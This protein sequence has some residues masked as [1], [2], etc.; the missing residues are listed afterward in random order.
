MDSQTCHCRDANGMRCYAWCTN[1]PM[2]VIALQVA[3]IYDK[4]LLGRSFCSMYQSK[5]FGCSLNPSYESGTRHQNSQVFYELSGCTCIDNPGAQCIATCA[6]NINFYEVVTVEGTG[7][8]LASC[9]KLG[10]SVLGCSVF[11][12]SAGGP[13]SWTHSRIKNETTCECSTAKDSLLSCVAFCGFLY[14][15]IS[16]A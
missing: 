14:V 5:L 1:M 13:T 3:N 16:N 9:S 11:A 4:N 2:P 12:P 8:V 7:T 10:N 15:Y 6:P